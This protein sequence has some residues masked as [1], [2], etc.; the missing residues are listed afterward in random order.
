LPVAEVQ[1]GAANGWSWLETRRSGK[2]QDSGSWKTALAFRAQSANDR[3]HFWPVTP[4]GTEGTVL[5][6]DSSP[7]SSQ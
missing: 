3:F 2:K 7:E 4:L 5:S 6:L 1:A